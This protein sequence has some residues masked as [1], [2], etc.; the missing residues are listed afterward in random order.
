MHFNKSRIPTHSSNKLTH[1]KQGLFMKSFK[2]LH[3]KSSGVMQGRHE[4]PTVGVDKHGYLK[5]SKYYTFSS[6]QYLLQGSTWL[7]L[8]QF[9][10]QKFSDGWKTLC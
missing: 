1:V 3:I 5:L 6:I 2:L 7:G 4:N 8:E 10:K 9:S